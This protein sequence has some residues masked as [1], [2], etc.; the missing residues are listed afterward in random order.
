MKR[1]AY[2]PVSSP[3]QR[4]RRRVEES[5]ATSSSEREETESPTRVANDEV[6]NSIARN[7]SKNDIHIS[8]MDQDPLTEPPT[9]AAPP[10]D[11]SLL[12]SSP[13]RA[14]GKV[15]M[16]SLEEIVGEKKDSEILRRHVN[17]TEVNS[18]ANSNSPSA[19]AWGRELERLQEMA[20][21]VYEE[22]AKLAAEKYPA[23]PINRASL[24]DK[25][26]R[27]RNDNALNAGR[28]FLT[29]L[30]NVSESL[31]ED[32]Q[33]KRISE[34]NQAA[35]LAR[36]AALREEL[37]ALK[38]ENDDDN[39][40]DR[41]EELLASTTERVTD[42]RKHLEKLRENL[43]D[44]D[45]QIEH[46]ATESVTLEHTSGTLD[47]FV[48]K[49]QEHIGGYGFLTTCHL[50][51]SEFSLTLP[52]LTLKIEIPSGRQSFLIRKNLAP[53]DPEKPAVENVRCWM[54]AVGDF[55]ANH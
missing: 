39:A 16:N 34:R 20:R 44:S 10:V 23:A 15:T 32:E 11:D 2:S 9:F 29:A 30:K 12:E 48:R 54:Q 47:G 19:A 1:A 49:L 46:L 51:E 31:V 5:H 40:S 42:L 7:E 14:S 37:A 28:I 52:F 27:L 4:H 8:S 50:S 21:D 36:L 43:K 25:W 17:M 53:L 26:L 33:A 24:A 6:D 18:G 22:K 45:A 41:T 38:E 3:S 35:G 13:V 55:A